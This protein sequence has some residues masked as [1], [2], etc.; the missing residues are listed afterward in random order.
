MPL[1]LLDEEDLR[2]ALRP[3]QP[4]PSAFEAGIRERLAVAESLPAESQPA[5][6]PLA[7]LSPWLKS[8][9]A[10]LPL[11]L[12]AGCKGTAIAAKLSPA[13]GASKLLSYLAFPAISLF[14]LIAAALIS[15]FK[16]RGI[17][18]QAGSQL[19]DQLAVNEARRAWWQRHKWAAGTVFGISLLLM[20]LGA[21]SLL[22]F[23]YLISFGL[24]V[25]LLASFA[26]AGLGS[27]QVV[28]GTC[29]MGLIFMAQAV[30]GSRLG[31]R[32]IHFLDQQLVSAVF[33]I[34]VLLLL[35]FVAAVPPPAVSPAVSLPKTPRWYWFFC[36][37]FAIFQLLMVARILSLSRTRSWSL[38]FLVANFIFAAF[39]PIAVMLF[40]SQLARLRAGSSTHSPAKALVAVILIPLLI[41]Q[42]SSLFWPATPARI[43]R[44]VES[45]RSARFSSATWHQW[46]IVARWTIDAKL[47]PDLT[48]PRQL[49]AEEI[50]GK[51]NS[52]VLG[53]ALRVGLLPADQ[54]A[55]LRDY[56]RQRRHLFNDRFGIKPS[57]VHIGQHDWVIRAAV[58]KNDLSPAERDLLEQRLRET[59]DCL[60]TD[61]YAKLETALRITQL[62]DVI[63]RPLDRNHYRPLIHDLLRAF[64]I[65]HGPWH[66]VSGGFKTYV[67]TTVGDLQTTAHAVELMEIYG[68]PD[69]LDIAW[70]RSFLSHYAFKRIGD[71]QWIAAA[72]LN[73]LDALPGITQPTWLEIL[74]SERTLFAAIVLVSLCLYATLSSP[75]VLPTPALPQ[76][77]P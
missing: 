71:Q 69:G 28:A 18:T 41:W 14:V 19:S 31:S 59:L 12:L 4:D 3:F 11:E 52:Y 60:P 43:Q 73:R 75:S 17:H 39:V 58:L 29:L 45:F 44:H 22:F 6:E 77:P 76:Q 38:A 64:H 9:A 48:K 68:I 54:I 33:Y 8:A 74:Y 61:Q 1:E 67:R 26:K 47:N 51:Q 36:A 25:Y 35:P 62:L 27:R 50:A 57:S 32:E 24:L 21:T 42:T 2:A 20:W 55:Q 65:Q 70:V 5:E 49:L 15:A 16:I 63:G 13:T 34:G 40:K 53:S 10:F 66:S 72:A 46:E 56:D 7:N 23:F 30:G 37:A